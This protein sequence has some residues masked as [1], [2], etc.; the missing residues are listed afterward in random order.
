MGDVGNRL[1][2]FI[3]D[4]IFHDIQLSSTYFSNDS[5][6]FVLLYYYLLVTGFCNSEETS[7]FP[8]GTFNWPETVVGEVARLQC[9]ETT[10]ATRVC[11]NGAIWGDPNFS[12][13][14][15]GGCK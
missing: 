9:S 3:S 15:S 5:L 4:T 13:C 7:I 8:Y 1:S 12:Q 11:N 14:N 2:S 6:K 10:F